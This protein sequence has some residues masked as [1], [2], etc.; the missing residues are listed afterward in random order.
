MV[1]DQSYKK[2][3]TVFTIVISPADGQN[4]LLHS[5]ICP[6]RTFYATSWDWILSKPV[7]ARVHLFETIA[8]TK[9]SQISK[10]ENLPGFGPSQPYSWIQLHPLSKH[11]SALLINE[12]ASGK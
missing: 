11:A 7:Q 12:P 10:H 6:C 2:Y 8:G 3:T 5:G 1:R 4:Q 9:L